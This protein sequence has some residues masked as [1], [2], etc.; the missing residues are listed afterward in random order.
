MRLLYFTESY[1]YGNGEKWKQYEL[2]ELSK[3]FSDITVVPFY[4]GSNRD[5]PKSPIEGIKYIEPLFNG[6]PSASIFAKIVQ[7]IISKHRRIFVQELFRFKWSIVRLSQWLQSSYLIDE[8]RRIEWVKK[9]L[10]D[11]S[12]STIAYFFWGRKSS[13]LATL[14]NNKNNINWIIRFH[15]YDLYSY[16]YESQ[17]V[18]YQ[19]DQVKNS[20]LLLTISEDG[21]RYLKKGYKFASGKI[22]VNKLGAVSEGITYS[23]N[24][25]L[26]ITS[27]SRL[28]PLKRVELIAESLK[29]IS[30]LEIKWIHIGD[31][32]NRSNIEAIVNNIGINIE[33]VLL[34]KINSEDVLSIYLSENVDL[35]LNMSTSEG[36]PVSIME[37]M[38]AGIPVLATDV[39]GTAEI[40]NDLNGKLLKKDLTPVQ[41]AQELMEYYR[42]EKETKEMKRK[43]AFQTYSLMYNARINSNE[44]A[45]L[46]K[47]KFRN[48]RN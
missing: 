23:N 3:H 14:I 30:N 33:V 11:S 5:N 13:K 4:Y 47:K 44:F 19:F 45:E 39:G 32:I 9:N 42:L 26:V 27:C 12:E 8:M 7:I 21:R 22:V 6:I 35:F 43:A 37:A 15:R 18:P 1:P 24:N 2:E 31:G 25:K 48:S 17:Y 34:G 28:V 38:S 40:V 36:I 10:L 16:C 29:L 46:L 41:L 20:D